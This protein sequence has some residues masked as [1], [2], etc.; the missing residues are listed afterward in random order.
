[1]TRLPCACSAGH[2]TFGRAVA[3]LCSATGILRT[4][5]REGPDRQEGAVSGGRLGRPPRRRGEGSSEVTVPDFPRTSRTRQALSRRSVDM[6]RALAPPRQAI[7][8]GLR[9]RCKE[10][11]ASASRPARWLSARQMVPAPF[12]VGRAVEWRSGLVEDDVSAPAQERSIA[13]PFLDQRPFSGTADLRRTVGH[14]G[15]RRGPDPRAGAGEWAR[16]GGRLL[17]RDAQVFAYRDT[18]AH[19]RRRPTGVRR[20]GRR[21]WRPGRA[22]EV[23]WVFFGAPPRPG[24]RG[25]GHL[26]PRIGNF[27]VPLRGILPRRVT[28]RSAAGSRFTSPSATIEGRIPAKAGRLSPGSSGLRSISEVPSV[29][30]SVD[31][32]RPPGFTRTCRPRGSATE[33]G[34]SPASGHKQRSC[35]I[36]SSR[37]SSLR[38]RARRGAGAVIE[39]S[40]RQ[41]GRLHIAMAAS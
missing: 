18:V 15:A 3:K 34:S 31:R 12:R 33:I 19:A 38:R 32:D 2:H 41:H 1:M 6:R 27:R 28:A 13:V 9:P 24:P 40:G 30:P 26:R 8:R 22:S 37:P 5:G 16:S 21:A 35:G 14:G 20:R 23:V 4:G 11:C 7:W 17:E 25:G 10:P 36:P 29:Y 39:G